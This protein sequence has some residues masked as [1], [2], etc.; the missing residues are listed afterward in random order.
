MAY[1]AA[2]FLLLSVPIHIALEYCYQKASGR[3]FRKPYGS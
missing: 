3:F 1:A 2:P